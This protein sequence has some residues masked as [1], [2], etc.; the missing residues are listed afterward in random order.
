MFADSTGMT[1]VILDLIAT[2]TETPKNMTKCDGVGMTQASVPEVDASGESNRLGGGG[3]GWVDWVELVGAITS[4][5]HHPGTGVLDRKTTHVKFNGD[6]VI[7]SKGTKGN[8]ISN[9][10]GR[11]KYV[12]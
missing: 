8:K 4:V 3:G 6:R 10:F 7:T 11:D 5:E 1:S 2:E 9:E 12:R